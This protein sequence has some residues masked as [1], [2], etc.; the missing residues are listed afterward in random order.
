MMRNDLKVADR[1]MIF[2]ND[3]AETL[4]FDDML[5]QA[6]VTCIRRLAGPRAAVPMRAKTFR[7]ATTSIG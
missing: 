6:S 4:E 2:N 3:L 1:S 5:A 7:S